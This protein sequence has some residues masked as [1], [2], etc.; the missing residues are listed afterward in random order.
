MKIISRVQRRDCPSRCS[1]CGKGIKGGSLATGKCFRCRH[2]IKRQGCPRCGGISREHYL[3]RYGICRTCR[4]QT[5]FREITGR[6]RDQ[7]IREHL[8]WI[9]TVPDMWARAEGYSRLF[10]A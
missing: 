10:I 1:L 7:V 5:E 2:E 4:H 6:E 9:S 3:R 8:Q